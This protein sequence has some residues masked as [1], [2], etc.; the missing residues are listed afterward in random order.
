MA[1]ESATGSV[2]LPRE[3]MALLESKAVA[4]GKTIDELANDSINAHLKQSRVRQ[5]AKAAY[6]PQTHLRERAI[7]PKE[8]ALLFIDIQNYNCH[9]SGAEAAHFGTVSLQSMQLQNHK[10]GWLWLQN[11]GSGWSHPLS[12]AAPF[13]VYKAA[14]CCMAIHLL[15]GRPC[16]RHDG[17]RV[18]HRPLQGPD[19]EYW[20]KRVEEVSPIWTGLRDT[21]R[22]AGIEVMYTVIQSLTA[23]GRDQ[24]L[25]Y[26]ISGFHVPPGSFDAQASPHGCSLAYQQSIYCPAFLVCSPHCPL[27][28]AA[29]LEVMYSHLARRQSCTGKQSTG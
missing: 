22:E 10:S 27:E 26:K 15:D 1:A 16:Q 6:K 23:D 14:A 25:D 24:S 28:M 20:W 19:M 4:E 11:C 12:A 29:P 21:C 5:A 17:A 7:V 8:A 13:S 2:T 18:A 3:T 9:R